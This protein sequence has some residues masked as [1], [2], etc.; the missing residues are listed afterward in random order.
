[1]IQICTFINNNNAYKDHMNNG[2]ITDRKNVIGKTS[3]LGLILKTSCHPKNIKKVHPG[4]CEISIVMG[5][6]SRIIIS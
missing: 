4:V 1:M 2:S 6:I 3:H 5:P